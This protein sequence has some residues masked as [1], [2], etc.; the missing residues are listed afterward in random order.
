MGHVEVDVSYMHALSLTLCS[1][2]F[3]STYTKVNHYTTKL[4]G[5]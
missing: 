1:E 4:N 5:H 2:T 3:S